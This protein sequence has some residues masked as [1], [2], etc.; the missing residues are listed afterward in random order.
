[1]NLCVWSD[2]V[3]GAR[4]AQPQPKPSDEDLAASLDLARRV[5]AD[6]FDRAKSSKQK[7]SLAEELLKQ[8]I[9]TQNDPAGK[10]TLLDLASK[11]YAG[12]G[13]YESA[14]AANQKLAANFE[15][16]V[17]TRHAQALATAARAASGPDEHSAFVQHADLL[18]DDILSRDRFELALSVANVAVASARK[19][20]DNA[21]LAA[22]RDRIDSI[23]RWKRQF[24]DVAEASETL[25]QDALDPEANLVV[26][27]Y[28]CFVKQNWQSGLPLLA[29]GSDD[30]LKVLAARDLS[31]TS[32]TNQMMARADAWWKYSDDETN[33]DHRRAQ[34]SRAAH[35]YSA[36]LP[37]LT[38]LNKARVEKQLEQLGLEMAQSLDLQSDT[39]LL[40]TFSRRK[41]NRRGNDYY[42]VDES[43][44]ANHGRL[45]GALWVEEG[46]A[47][48]SIDLDGKNHSVEYPN[49]VPLLRGATRMTLACWI[50][51]RQS[52][53][54]H[55]F[56]FDAGFHANASV[57][58]LYRNEE[59][60]FSLSTDHG[61][62]YVVAK[63][64]STDKWHHV[65]A[66]WDG[67]EQVL[68][69]DGQRVDSAATP[70]LKRLTPENLGDQPA[71]LGICAKRGDRRMGGW[72]F[73]GRIDELVVFRRALSDAEIGA[74]YYKGKAAESL[75]D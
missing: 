61:G 15:I 57:S 48:G 71:R 25:Q 39:V 41:I 75:T 37:D 69:V 3:R 13:D 5:Y 67:S 68:F 2:E 40:Q 47:G 65:A 19:S 22:M 6:E 12:A 29:L 17:L 33:A 24:A 58:L 56:I 42:V 62:A 7:R 4:L 54:E 23:A 49:L 31:D 64:I 9:E 16:D 36:A 27:K 66:V 20:R 73:N 72:Y 1:M 38:G 44:L 51:P 43:P 10:Y 55:A 60:A 35:W 11:I 74:L 32:E 52:K 59:V 63:D 28:L 8:G 46:V 45:H 70:D 26:G 53:P 50:Y 30:A 34:R 14:A 18:L 21:K